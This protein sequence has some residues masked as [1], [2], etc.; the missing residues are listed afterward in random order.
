MNLP[1]ATTK[2]FHVN[3]YNSENAEAEKMGQIYKSLWIGNKLS[4]LEQLCIQSFVS[5]GARYELYCYEGIEG[6]PDDCQI[7]D[8]N[9]ILGKE[10]IFLYKNGS[11]AGFADWFRYELLKKTGGIWVDTDVYLLQKPGTARP[12]LIADEGNGKVNNAILGIPSNHPSLN[13]CIEECRR[14]G[15]DISWG[16]TGPQ[17]ITQAVAKFGLTSQLSPTYELYPINPDK[18]HWLL[19]PN[20]F[21]LVEKS[22]KHATY[23]HLWN[24]KI[25]RSNYDKNTPPPAGSYLEKLYIDSNLYNFDYTKSQNK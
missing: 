1:K 19:T 9:L 10:L 15:K 22:V 24:E 11:P 14:C 18:W 5:K 4:P 3:R 6:V 2:D 16:Q 17:L 20:T 25:R 12:F 7:K 21:S 8:A 13:F 23:L